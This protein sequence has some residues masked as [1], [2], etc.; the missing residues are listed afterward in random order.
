[1]HAAW[2]F[3]EENGVAQHYRDARIAA[4]YEGTNGIQAADLVTRKLPSLGCAVVK[5]ISTSCVR[6]WWRSRPSTTRRSVS[7][8]EDWARRSKASTARCAWLL[9][10]LDKRPEAALAGAVPYLRLFASTA[11]VL[12]SSSDEALAAGAARRWRRSGGTHRD[13]AVLRRAYAVQSSG[14]SAK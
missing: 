13:G 4:I 3:I 1:V 7:P 10:E 11:G 14:S 5:P 6:T 12:C 9:A 2:A 8:R